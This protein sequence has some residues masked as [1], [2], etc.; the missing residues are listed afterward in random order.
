[1]LVG[2]MLPSKRC[3][4]Q[5]F[6]QSKQASGLQSNLEMRSASVQQ[7]ISHC[8]REI[9]SGPYI[10]PASGHAPQEKPVFIRQRC[11]FPAS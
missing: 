1:M 8:G 9:V 5:G 11:A 2:H 6:V 3:Q 10:D 4:Q 7:L